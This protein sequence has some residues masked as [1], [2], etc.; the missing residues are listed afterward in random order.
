M[1][2]LIGDGDGVNNSDI[3]AGNHLLTGFKHANRNMN[4]SMQ[5]ACIFMFNGPEWQMPAKHWRWQARRN[6]DWCGEHNAINNQHTVGANTKCNHPLRICHQI[7]LS[8][9]CIS[10]ECYK[11]FTGVSQVLTVDNGAPI[12][13]SVLWA[14]WTSA[15]PFWYFSLMYVTAIG[16][17]LFSSRPKILCVRYAHNNSKQF[18]LS[19]VYHP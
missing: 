11:C 5:Y 1:F 15:F 10:D 12:A 4:Y 16:L 13:I 6:Q 17:F 19:D 3:F 7:C 8:A 9:A 14:H 18:G 2:S